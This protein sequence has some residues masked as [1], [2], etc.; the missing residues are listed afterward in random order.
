MPKRSLRNLASV[1]LSVLL[2]SGCEIGPDYKRPKIDMPDLSAKE[3]VSQFISKK[4]WNVFEDSALNH[5]E[6]L[7]LKRNADLRQAIANVDEARAAV[8]ISSAD[9]LPTLGVK[10]EGVKNYISARGKSYMPGVSSKR[11]AVDYLGAASA[12]Y[13]LDFFGKYRRADEVVRAILLS[14]RAARETVLLAVTADVAKVYFLLRSLD[15]KLAIAKRTLKTRQ[16]S[17]QVY[18]SRFLNGYCTELDYLR[19]ESDMLSVNTTVI[20]LESEVARAET[21]LSVLIGSSPKEMI[22]RATSKDKAIEKLN[23]PS[24]VPTG[25]PSDILARRPD[26]LQAEAQLIA[27]NAKIGEAR[28]AH[29]PSIS[30]TGIFGFESNSLASLFDTGSSMWNFVGG[31]SLPI[32]AGGRIASLEGV[33]KA[34]YR[35]MLVAYEKSIQTAFKETLDALISNRKNREIVVSRTRQVDALKKSYRIALKQKESGLIG[36]L[37]LL[38]VERG[39]LSAEMELVGALQ[40][41]LNATVDLCKALGGGWKMP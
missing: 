41:Q 14:T 3:E 5:L 20:N 29:F 35:K 7:A 32:F 15:A 9:L 40:N 26:I 37:D 22:N 19:I 6:E 11:N 34:R 2:L 25:I 18:K 33:A 21:L 39:L 1:T 12:S 28:A 17:N 16:E 24:S 10:G 23:I 4:W 30:L 13:E 8:G 38:D 36:L 31:I 27:A